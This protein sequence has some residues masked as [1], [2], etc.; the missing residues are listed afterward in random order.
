MVVGKQGTESGFDQESNQEDHANSEFADSISNPMRAET[1]AI[2]EVPTLLS[3][4]S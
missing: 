4:W 2:A 3:P 1:P